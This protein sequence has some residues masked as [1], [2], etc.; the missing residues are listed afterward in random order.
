MVGMLVDMHFA[1]LCKQRVPAQDGVVLCAE[2]HWHQCADILAVE[3]APLISEQFVECLQTRPVCARLHNTLVLGTSRTG[4]H[5]PDGLDVKYD[6][7]SLGQ[8]TSTSCLSLLHLA[9]IIVQ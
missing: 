8:Q 7:R 6:G 4:H 3:L 5:W 9:S 2:G 1:Q